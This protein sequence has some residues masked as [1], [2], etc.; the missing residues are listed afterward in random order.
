MVFSSPLP[1]TLLNSCAAQSSAALDLLLTNPRNHHNETPESLGSF[2]LS[3]KV[4]ELFRLSFKG[5][6][7]HSL[8]PE[9]LSLKP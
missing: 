9:A 2:K 7:L 3:E 6:A 8:K 1:A 5:R 4:L